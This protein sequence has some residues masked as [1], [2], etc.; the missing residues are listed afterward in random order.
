MASVNIKYLMDYATNKKVTGQLVMVPK[1]VG[2]VVRHS[3][4]LCGSYFIY[5]TNKTYMAI[6][7]ITE[8]S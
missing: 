2:W 3:S 8:T 5:L 6:K 4:E 7:T 1:Q